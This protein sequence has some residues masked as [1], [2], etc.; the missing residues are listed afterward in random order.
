M[1]VIMHDIAMVEVTWMD[2][3]MTHLWRRS[4]GFLL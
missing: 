4:T 1:G 3:I 2:A